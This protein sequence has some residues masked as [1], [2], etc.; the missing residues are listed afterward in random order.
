MAAVPDD[1]AQN[2]VPTSAATS[3][4]RPQVKQASFVRSLL[5]GWRRYFWR[6]ISVLGAMGLLGYGAGSV[7]VQTA[8]YFSASAAAT[9]TPIPAV[10]TDVLVVGGTP[11]GVAAAIGAARQGATVYLIEDRPK[12]GGDI[13][14]AML[15][16]FDVPLPKDGSQQSPVAYGFFGEVYRQLGVAFDISTAEWLFEQKLKSRPSIKVLKNTKIE[17]VRLRD[18]RFS[19]VLLSLP[20]GT[21]REVRAAVAIDATNDADFA[22][23]CGA[24][25]TVGRQLSNPDRAMQSAGLLFSVD[26]VRWKRVRRYV[27]SHRALPARDLDDFKHGAANAIDV[28][29]K[30]SRARL[31]LGG[32]NGHYAWERGDIVKDYKPRGDDV[33]MMSVNFGRQSDGSVVLNTLNLIHVNGL[34][35]QAKARAH[36]EAVKELPFFIAHL[37]NTMPGFSRAR[38]K[39]VAPELY[40]RETRHIAGF[41]TLTVDDVRRQRAFADRIAL[42]SYP[43]DLHPYGRHDHNPFGPQRYFYSLPLRAL[44][45]RKADGVFVASR[46]LSATYSA[47]GS[48]RVIPITMAAGEAA[49]FAAALCA[50]DKITPH[51]LVQ[52]KKKISELQARLR[53]AGIKIGDELAK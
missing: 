4:A 1:L 18:G 6:R 49:G 7:S 30:G 33:L 13:V 2:P 51:T 20:D 53:K 16:M 47:A 27:R 39:K 12:L 41:H 46:S 28:R 45:P 23:R 17:R 43:L 5:R 52:D 29:I 22:A 21:K 50:R 14:Y 10:E 26:G 36:A 24:G 42:C 40:V 11:S 31:R 32:V 48:A 15:N 8:N 9:P 34:D 44:V 3:P 37:R 19:G 38:L 35:E 25:Y